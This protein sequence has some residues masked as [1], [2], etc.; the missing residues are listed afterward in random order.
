[1]IEQFTISPIIRNWDKLYGNIILWKQSDKTV[2]KL[3][4]KKFILKY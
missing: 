3:T 2:Q 1:M 4:F